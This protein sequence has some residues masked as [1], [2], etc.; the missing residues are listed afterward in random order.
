MSNTRRRGGGRR[1]IRSETGVTLS[2][3]SLRGWHKEAWTLRCA[4]NLVNSWHRRRRIDQCAYRRVS[5]SA[6]VADT[7]VQ[8]DSEAPHPAFPELPDRKRATLILRFSADLSV[9]AHTSRDYK[10]Y[11]AAC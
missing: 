11:G 3:S 6:V 1:A 2:R 10:R 7:E 4:I 5:A 9:K 8:N